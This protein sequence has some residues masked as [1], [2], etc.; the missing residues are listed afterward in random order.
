MSS[1]KISYSIEAFMD[2]LWPNQT[3]I[4]HWFSGHTMKHH[5]HLLVYVQKLSAISQSETKGYRSPGVPPSLFLTNV[6]FLYLRLKIKLLMTVSQRHNPTQ[7]CK[8]DR[9]QEFRN[10][11]RQKAFGTW[12][13]RGPLPKL[14]KNHVG[15][16]PF[17]AEIRIVQGNR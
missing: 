2:L 8:C 16:W 6:E 9:C 17:S 14:I 4:D 5:W 12:H 7:V 3:K 15:L 10:F 13:L 11:R 1:W